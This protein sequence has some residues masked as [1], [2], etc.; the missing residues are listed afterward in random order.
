[1]TNLLV[2]DR[3]IFSIIRFLNDFV[4]SVVVVGI[5]FVLL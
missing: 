3:S 5:L 1:M 4:E 2:F